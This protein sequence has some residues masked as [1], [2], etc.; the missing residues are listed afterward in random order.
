MKK[1][2][3]FFINTLNSG[4]AEKV[5]T[6]LLRLFNPEKFDV[7]VLTICGGVNQEYIPNHVH[8]KP[9][10]KKEGGVFSNIYKKILFH[11][12][13]KLFAFFYLKGKYDVEIAYLEGSATRFL[14]A[15]KSKAKKIAFVHCD[16]SKKDIL[17]SFYKNK[18]ACLKEYTSFN[19]VCFV[20][21]KSK[22]G[23]ENSIG[24]LPNAIVLHNVIDYERVKALAEEKNETNYKTKG[25]KLI[26]VGRLSKEKGFDRLLH[27][28]AELE[29][30]YQFELWIVGD[31]AEFDSLQAYIQQ[32]GISSV[33]M[34]GFQ[35]NPYAFIKK[36][37]IF[38][39]SSIFEGYSTAVLESLALGIPV[40]T[41]R[42][43]GM[44]EILAG[45]EFGKVVDNSEQGLKDGLQ[46]LLEDVN[47]YPRL[48]SA[49]KENSKKMT[50]SESVL[51]YVKLL[52]TES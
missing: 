10:I 48:K 39:S 41:T 17:A 31:G 16:V 8:Y 52:E 4:G 33:R 37:D 38:I 9:I 23:F 35:K 5:L 3:R 47:I 19:T 34:L 30:N 1:K 26:T 22:E 27:V 7:A 12:P 20:S 42:T 13:K 6:D 2:I 46:E 18:A 45:G 50:N 44:E 40:L 29:K 43:A 24:V 36:A 25:L 11:L 21:E 51:G 49:A 32:N 14:A 28:V 15:S